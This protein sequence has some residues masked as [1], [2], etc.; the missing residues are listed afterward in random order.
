[1][2][3]I[4]DL[5]LISM[6]Q[7]STRR[8]SK[9]FLPFQEQDIKNKSHQIWILTKLKIINKRIHA[10]DPTA[11]K[12]QMPDESQTYQYR[13]SSTA[14]SVQKVLQLLVCWFAVQLALLIQATFLDFIWCRAIIQILHSPALVHGALVEQGNLKARKSQCKIQQ[15]Q[16]GEESRAL[17]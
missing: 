1:M 3:S 9:Q 6:S 15:N 5:A 10:A 13:N 14:D 17:S 11:S 12:I 4:L 8:N 7:L 2:L 16:H